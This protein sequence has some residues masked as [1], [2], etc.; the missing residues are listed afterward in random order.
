MSETE[1]VAALRAREAFRHNLGET[2]AWLKS[3]PLLPEE[4]SEDDINQL[5]SDLNLY[6]RPAVD[7]FLV[8]DYIEDALKK[9]LETLRK[10]P[11]NNS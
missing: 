7:P 6:P 1:V 3:V 11:D 9:R 10:R 8:P 2:L 5:T 4:N